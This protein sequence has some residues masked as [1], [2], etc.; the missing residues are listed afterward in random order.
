VDTY[1]CPH[2]VWEERSGGYWLYHSTRE[3]DSWTTPHRIDE[4]SGFRPVLTCDDRGN[5]H[6]VWRGTD[7]VWHIV[8]SDSGWSEKA[9]VTDSATAMLPDLARES[10]T[11]HLT[12]RHDWGVYYCGHEL[13]GGVAE[14]R[15]RPLPKA[16][17]VILPD[18]RRL[19]LEVRVSGTAS[20]SLWDSAGRKTFARDLGYLQPG[21][22]EVRL[23]V[24]QVPAGRYVCRLLVGDYEAASAVVIVR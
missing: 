20:V 19:R 10:Q 18:G 17:V 15:Q 7:K 23:P 2:V 8:R 3:A 12:W 9:L 21:V 22:H 6:A 4:Q 24:E 13:P 11:L 16:G 1:D 14:E 5:T